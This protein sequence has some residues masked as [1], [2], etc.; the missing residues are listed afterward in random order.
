MNTGGGA[1]GYDQGAHIY[2][3][4]SPPPSASFTL[5]TYSPHKWQVEKDRR[6]WRRHPRCS[7]RASHSEQVSTSSTPHSRVRRMAL[8]WSS[9]ALP[10]P[11]RPGPDH[12]ID[13]SNRRRDPRPRY[14]EIT[15]E[16]GSRPPPPPARNRRPKFRS[17]ASW[18]YPSA[19][20]K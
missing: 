12:A 13:A 1:I 16:T 18:A 2:H 5:H 3:M 19:L 14:S 6:R 17:D 7:P 10:G 4:I 11:V 15:A 8:A 9:G 20:R